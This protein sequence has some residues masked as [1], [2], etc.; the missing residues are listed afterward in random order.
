VYSAEKRE[1]FTV[2]S[3]GEE[4]DADAEE[5]E[6]IDDLLTVVLDVVSNVFE[7]DRSSRGQLESRFSG[8][9]KRVITRVVAIRHTDNN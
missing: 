2:E 5:D 4:Q 8:S 7:E 1:F 9:T 6:E 3:F